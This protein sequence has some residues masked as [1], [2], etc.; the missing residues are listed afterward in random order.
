MSQKDTELKN[1]KN[2][3]ENI[4]FKIYNNDESENTEDY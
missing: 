2:Y 4:N 1:H 3:A